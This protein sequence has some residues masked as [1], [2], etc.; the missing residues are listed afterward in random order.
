MK[1]LFAAIGALALAATVASAQ[2][3]NAGIET[4]NAG[5]TALET[6]KTE[7]LKQKLEE[8]MNMGL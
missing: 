4:F 3:Y 5:A 6:N 1:R 8:E 2:D 7:A